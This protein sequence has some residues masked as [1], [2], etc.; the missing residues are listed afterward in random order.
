MSIRATSDE[1]FLATGGIVQVRAED[2]ALVKQKGTTN[3]RKRARLCAHPGPTDTL[4]EMLIVLDRGTYIRPHRHGSKAE[5]FHIIEGELDVVIFHDD[6]AVREVVRMGPY[7]SGKAFYYRIMEP[8]YHSVLIHTPYALF[9]ETTNGPFNRT[10][11]E[12]APWS[13]AEGG[14]GVAEFVEKIRAA[15]AI[16]Q[17]A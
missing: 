4:H 7:S 5:S 17:A 1:V 12:F 2:V 9:H 11:T 13:P 16:K 6:G 3:A 8:C 15:T 10:D 14:E